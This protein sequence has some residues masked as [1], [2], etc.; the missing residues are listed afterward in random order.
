[1]GF[2]TNHVLSRLAAQMPQ[3]D[4]QRLLGEQASEVLAVPAQAGPRPTKTTPKRVWTAPT[5]GQH[6]YSR[7]AGFHE[8][9]TAA[10]GC[11]VPFD[12]ARKRI[13]YL[14]Q[15]AREVHAL[16]VDHI[17]SPAQAEWIVHHLTPAL[18]SLRA[19]SEWPGLA[20][21]FPATMDA[22]GCAI[23]CIEPA[24]GLASSYL[25]HHPGPYDVSRHRSTIPDN[26]E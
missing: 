21:S 6:L 12:T 17:T 20:A 25:W 4:L 13:F 14:A 26:Q 23:S 18:A 8:L 11:G 22:V 1:M 19:I 16:A 10:E 15:A 3:D 9:C 24:L 7:A 2:L 5:P